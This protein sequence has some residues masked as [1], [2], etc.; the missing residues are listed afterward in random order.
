MK[1]ILYLLTISSLLGCEVKSS[2]RIEYSQTMCKLP[3]QTYI[4][5]KAQS[6]VNDTSNLGKIL[7]PQRL[8]NLDTALLMV[9]H[10]ASTKT[11][12]FLAVCKPKEERLPCSQLA[13]LLPPLETANFLLVKMSCQRKN[14][15]QVDWFA[16]ENIIND[17]S[18]VDLNNDGLKELIFKDEA[19]C[20]GG[21][22]Y[23]FYYIQSLKNDTS[24][25]LYANNTFD[26]LMMFPFHKHK[27]VVGDTIVKRVNVN[28]K[29]V[30]Q[31]GIQEIEEVLNYA[32]YQGGKDHQQAEKLVKRG[33]RK[34]V[35][36]LKEGYYKS[37]N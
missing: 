19:V 21:I 20:R 15:W 11:L 14:K 17:S 26:K 25:K 35:L 36:Y 13:S 16:Q 24:T 32:I 2:H 31:D 27:V 10:F 8:Q 5:Q 7:L 6:L 18:L 3:S 29:D 22:K 9:D 34:R 1:T 33:T 4:L 28:F 23:G 12:E 30:N 37:L